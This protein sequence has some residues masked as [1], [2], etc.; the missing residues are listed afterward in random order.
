MHYSR[1]AAHR[2]EKRGRVVAVLLGAFFVLFRSFPFLF[3]LPF[4]NSLLCVLSESLSFS[5][6]QLLG[7]GEDRGGQ[8][9]DRSGSNNE[10]LK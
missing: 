6:C 7:E 10:S 3:P 5:A 1:G 8:Y 4:N 2:R 9:Y